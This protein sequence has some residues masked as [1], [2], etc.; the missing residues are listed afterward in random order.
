MR[1]LREQILYLRAYITEKDKYEY[2]KICC[3]SC[4]AQATFGKTKE[5]GAFFLR[6]D[7]EGKVIWESYKP[8]AEKST[9]S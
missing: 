4:K 1:A 6:K 8:A 2:V 9:A 3:A 7:D 5:E